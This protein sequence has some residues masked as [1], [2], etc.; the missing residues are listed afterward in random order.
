[1]PGITRH[2][3]RMLAGQ[4]CLASDPALRQAHHRALALLARFGGPSRPF[5]SCEQALAA[6]HACRVLQ[7]R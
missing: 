4:P 3:A 7:P 1:M 2:K 6:G 5:P